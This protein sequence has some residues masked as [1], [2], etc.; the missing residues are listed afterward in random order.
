MAQTIFKVGGVPEH[1][2]FPW[3]LAEEEAAFASKS[4]NFQWAAFPGGTGAMLEALDA[5]EIDLALMLTEGAVAD[6]VKGGAHRIVGTYVQSPLTWGIHVHA[7]SPFHTVADLEGQVFG[8]SR[9]QSG[10]HLMAYV[11]ARDMGWDTTSLRFEVI[12]DFEGARR[13]MSAGTVHGFMWE[14]YTT[15]PTVDS[16]E[17]RRVGECVTPWPCF[18]MVARKEVFSCQ[19]PELLQ[20]MHQIRQLM[21]SLSPEQ[22]KAYISRRFK[23][24]P[25]DV[26]AW[27][28]QTEW[29]CAP[30]IDGAELE[31]TQQALRALGIIDQI[32]PPKE[33]C[34]P[35][36]IRSA[37][38]LS[39]RMYDWRV[40]S[41]YRMLDMQ[42]K[43][44][45]PL[46]VSDLTA[47]GHLDQYHYQGADLCYEV[48]KTLELSAGS[49]V[50]D[51]GSG[52][53]GTARVLADCSG[54]RVLG[55]ELQPELCRLGSEL[56]QR[57]GLSD[58]VSFL[59]GDFLEYDWLEKFSHF[60]SLLVFLHVP[61]RPEALRHAS[62]SLV[63]G[64]SFFIEDFVLRGP[65]TAEEQALLTGTISGVAVTTEDA[66][67]AD[68]A[69]A[70]L[71]VGAVERMDELWADWTS[72]RRDDFKSEAEQHRA[73][74]G[75][76]LYEERLAFYEA[77]A[78]LFSGKRLGGVR[79]IG[80]KA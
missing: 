39:P 37:Q 70:G 9:Y 67:L 62:R 12:K 44:E 52:V 5:G 56:T 36:C 21:D 33:L 69:A 23:L 2:N 29:R 43:G 11:N 7:Q 49:Y 65:L 50:Y 41:V 73:F 10:S 24:Q 8:I 22:H 35:S 53:G 46:S 20:L 72:R 31:K 15:K 19:Q 25:Q 26:D 51:I 57:A 17:W 28:A 80:H 40:Q 77:V 14:K 32:L 60:I 76:A 34:A 78:R 4:V 30:E 55:V 59:A 6:I 42:G 13:A 27:Y 16:G 61:N 63:A 75:A 64:G 48:A 68:L 58:R 18:V 79:I 38:A 74:F 47:L 66:Y 71:S 3:Y 54:C 45:G 1:F